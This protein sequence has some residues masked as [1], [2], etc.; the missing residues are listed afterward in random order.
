MTPP[1]EDVAWC[2]DQT[3][4]ATGYGKIR[5]GVV[6]AVLLGLAWVWLSPGEAGTG[7][8]LANIALGGIALMLAI[9]VVDSAFKIAVAVSADHVLWRQCRPG[10]PIQ[11][12]PRSEIAAATVFDGDRTV[13]LHGAAGRQ[14]RFTGIAAP[15]DMA[16]SLGVRVEVWIDQ[17]DPGHGG[18]FSHGAIAFATGIAAAW[19]T[20]LGYGLFLEGLPSIRML[21][22][23]LLVLIG[24]VLLLLGVHWLS[25][26]RMSNLQRREMACHMLDP[27][28][29]GRDPYTAGIPW[30]EV[31]TV[32]FRSWL[33]RH[34]YGGPHDCRAG[35][36]PL[37]YEPGYKVP[38]PERETA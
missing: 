32:T 17:G 13:L 6:G 9:S 23:H 33:V 12:I 31:P 26:R 2:N 37:I 5:I 19:S 24:G 8:L 29:G 15:R 22:G 18:K 4:R 14:Q 11:S 1:G 28:W 25:A 16:L 34:I 3:T 10:S 36:E 38:E 27:I 21:V 7:I 30:W 35:L 20:G